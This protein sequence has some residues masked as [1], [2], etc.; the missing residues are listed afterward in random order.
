MFLT[1]FF[2]IKAEITRENSAI[3]I[4]ENIWRVAQKLQNDFNN[5]FCHCNLKK[6]KKKC[7]TICRKNINIETNKGVLGVCEVGVK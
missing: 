4:C 5:L 3:V 2:E 1:Y 6:E 7:K